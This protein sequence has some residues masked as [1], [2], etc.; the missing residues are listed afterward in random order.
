M[1]RNPVVRSLMV[2][3]GWL[4]LA[5]CGQS[6]GNLFNG[7]IAPPME[8]PPSV[9]MMADMM[10]AEPVPESPSPVLETPASPAETTRNDLPLTGDDKPP[11]PPV[12]EEPPP[13]E[14]QPEGPRVL[15]VAPANGTRGVSN[16]VKIVIEFSVPMDEAKTEASYQSEG[17]P[18]NSVTFSWNDEGTELTITPNDPLD[19]PAGSDPAAVVS[20]PINFFLST[21]AQDREGQHLSAPA[22]S[23]FALL[24]QINVSLAAQQNR[25]L[26]GSWRS[27]DT[28]GQGDC[29]RNQDTVCV[30]DNGTGGLQLKGFMSFAL[31]ALPSEMVRLQSARLNLQIT[32]RAG[33]PFNGLGALTLDHAAFDAIGPE[34]FEADPLAAL[35]RIATAGNAG[36]VLQ[37]DVRNALAADVGTRDRAQFRLAFEQVTNENGNADALISTWDTQRIDVSYLIP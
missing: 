6:N 35:G 33:N 16:D 7:D 36:T 21:S 3:A 9:D 29:A 5:A 10:K 1:Q 20:P 24:R 23:S 18:S 37:V 14:M 11:P 22:E 32:Q 4:C 28:Y 17:I 34:A 19:Y 15:S 13:P 27:N 2:S 12:K 26:T 30:G 25:D 31:G 8:P